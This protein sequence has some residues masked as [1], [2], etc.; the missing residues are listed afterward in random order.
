[1]GK[2]SKITVMILGLCLLSFLI[3]GIGV[4]LW[5]K[6][7]ASTMV[8]KNETAAIAKTMKEIED[9]LGP[10]DENIEKESKVLEQ[11]GQSLKI[12]TVNL[13]DYQYIPVFL[14]NIQQAAKETNNELI[15]ISPGEIKAIDFNNPIF[16]AVTNPGEAT[17][18]T[19]PAP[20]SAPAKDP[21]KQY[22]SMPIT[23]TMK[24]TYVSNVR[25]LDK[26]RKFPQ[27]IYI[28]NFNMSPNM[29]DGKMMVNTTITASALIVPDQYFDSK[30]SHNQADAVDTGDEIAPAKKATPA[31]PGNTNK[32][33][34][35]K[36]AKKI[37][38]KPGGAKP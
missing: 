28:R 29:V 9:K 5:Q 8:I 24:G 30:D 10:K 19:T 1:M 32:L 7:A 27:I 31:V 12:L 15:S 13:M 11:K 6:Q 3:I 36:P 20:P 18:A 14:K 35:T 37:I 26:L 23:M 22:K 25:F 2:Q 21:K 38:S 16:K 4:F 17:A 34:S 33:K